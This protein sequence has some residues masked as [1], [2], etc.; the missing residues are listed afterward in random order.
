MADQ[1]NVPSQTNTAE[2]TLNQLGLT[3]AEQVLELIQQLQ[4]QLAIATQA[5][6]Q[7]TT[8]PI[9]QTTPITTSAPDQTPIAVAES[10]NRIIHTP[11]ETDRMEDVQHTTSVVMAPIRMANPKTFSKQTTP[12]ELNMWIQDIQDYIQVGTA[13]GAFRTEQEKIRLAASYLTGEAKLKWSVAKQYSERTNDESQKINTFERFLEHVRKANT[14]WNEQ[15]RIRRKYM[16]LKQRRS[17]SE[18]ATEL[19]LLANQLVPVPSDTEILER[20]KYGLQERIQIE[21]ARVFDPPRDVHAFVE[22]CDRIDKRTYGYRF[23]YSRDHSFNAL[24]SE[25]SEH[26]NLPAKGTPEWTKLCQKENRCLECFK[27]GHRKAEC[28]NRNR[29]TDNKG[30][31]NSKGSEHKDQNQVQSVTFDVSKSQS[32]EKGKGSSRS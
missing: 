30:S 29:T 23:I 25:R 14:D 19:L 9:E 6:I 17:V 31:T 8:P 16:N 22:L 18:F 11:S 32:K 24:R 20:F 4:T 26:R 15:D 12:G 13:R 10:S 2:A 21:L 27:V 7:T 3:S 5:S 28:R 1:A